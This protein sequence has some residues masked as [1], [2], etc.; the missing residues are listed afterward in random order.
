[1]PGEW[2][3]I[4]TAPRDDRNKIDVLAKCWLRDR[5]AFVFARFPDCH[6]DAGDTMTNR[7]PRWAGVDANWLA[8]AWMSLPEIPAEWP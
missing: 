7:K 8:V 3:S 4:E 2:R 5:D 1:M 6:W